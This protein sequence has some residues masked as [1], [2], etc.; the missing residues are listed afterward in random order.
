MSC[1]STGD[2]ITDYNINYNDTDFYEY[3]YNI[4]PNG[5]NSNSSYS[6]K[7]NESTSNIS[8]LVDSE[9]EIEFIVELEKTVNITNYFIIPYYKEMVEQN[10]F[11]FKSEQCS[12]ERMDSGYDDLNTSSLIADNTNS[13]NYIYNGTSMMITILIVKKQ[14][15]SAVMVVPLVLI[16]PT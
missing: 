14:A 2:S 16:E 11:L 4:C 10:K 3:Q 9:S 7:Q 1:N 12:I 15:P 5:W 6:I 8:G 13:Y